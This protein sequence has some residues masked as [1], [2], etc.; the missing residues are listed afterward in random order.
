MRLVSCLLLFLIVACSART[1]A[2]EQIHYEKIAVYPHDP[3][4]WTQGLF[5]HEGRLYESTGLNGESSL[6][7]VDLKTGRIKRQI[8]LDERY[9][10]EGATLLDGKLYQLTWQA[11]W[12]FVYDPLTLKQAGQFTYSGEGWGLTDDDEQLIMSDGTA[13]IRFID[14]DRFEVKRKIQVKLKGR[15]LPELN[16]L[17]Y[18]NGYIYA[19]IWYRDEVAKIDPATGEVVGIIDFSGLWRQGRRTED[20][21]L[22]GIAYDASSGN[23]LITGKYW[24]ELFV[25]KLKDSQ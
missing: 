6:R 7:E 12:C 3:Q 14:P 2:V 9:F 1:G 11:G 22:N 20:Q 4:A 5:V 13:T 25:V 17:E 24:G 16:E 18:V 23:F 21:V 15:A 8:K 10:A 19:N